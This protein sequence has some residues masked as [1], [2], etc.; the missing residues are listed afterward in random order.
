[1]S[2]SHGHEGLHDI[3]EDKNGAWKF[4]VRINLR[5]DFALAARADLNDPVLKPLK[6]VLDKHGVTLKNQFDAFVSFC[7]EAEAAG[8]TDSPLYKWTKDTIEKP[9][10]QVAYATRFTVYDG[11]AQIYSE[12][13]ADAVIADFEP[14]KEAGMIVKIDKFNSD[15]A[16][17]PQAPAKYHR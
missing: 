16:K 3:G 10:K 15:P 9:V 14:L 2:K 1:M 6:D 13:L 17:N 8:Q 4:Q 12:A 7:R 11:D 5:K